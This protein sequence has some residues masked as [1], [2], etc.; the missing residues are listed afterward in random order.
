MVQVGILAVA[1]AVGCGTKPVEVSPLM[2]AWEVRYAEQQ[3]RNQW[4]DILSEEFRR[5][6]GGHPGDEKIP[7]EL[8]QEYR[9][10]I[11]EYVSQIDRIIDRRR[12]TT[13]GMEGIVEW[14]DGDFARIQALAYWVVCPLTVEIRLA[15]EDLWGYE[16]ILRA[17][18]KTNDEVG[19]TDYDNAAIK[20]I[21]TLEVGQPAAGAMVMAN[22]GK[23]VWAFGEWGDCDVDR[24]SEEATEE[25][26]CEA[27]EYLEGVLPEPRNE[28]WV[29]ERLR[30]GRY[31]DLD[32]EPL[33][34]DSRP[35]AEINLLPVHILVFMD[36][37]R[38]PNFLAHLAGSH[39]SIEVKHLRIDGVKQDLSSVSKVRGGKVDGQNITQDQVKGS[40]E[41]GMYIVPV[42]ILGVVRIFNPPDLEKV[43]TTGTV[44]RR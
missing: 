36:R 7:P 37:Q 35:Y 40:G 29:A 11:R 17:I 12:A 23:P 25:E 33:A 3:E 18:A 44:K 24:N 5:W 10:S 27:G 38:L 8:R 31:V 15:Q 21:E 22:R 28:D 9:A 34:A 2:N 4:P 16:A 14:N 13:N 43:N 42:E 41:D 20:R 30:T 32:G 1:G 39:M 26:G 6:I 19:A